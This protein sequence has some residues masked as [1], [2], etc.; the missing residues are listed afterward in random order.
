MKAKNLVVAFRPWNNYIPSSERYAD[1]CHHRLVRFRPWAGAL[2]SG[3]GS[4]EGIDL[5]HADETDNNRWIA[6]W[7]AIATAMRNLPLSER[8]VGFEARTL[9]TPRNEWRWSHRLDHLDPDVFEDTVS[10]DVLNLDGVHRQEAL[11]VDDDV[12]HWY[13]GTDVEWTRH[14]FA[15]RAVVD[16]EVAFRGRLKGPQEVSSGDGNPEDVTQGPFLNK[17][18]ADAVDVVQRQARELDAYREQRDRLVGGGAL[19]E[20]EDTLVAPPPLRAILTGTVGTSKTVVINSMVRAVGAESFLLLAPT[21]CAACNIG[22]QTIHSGLD[23]PCV[24]EEPAPQTA[25]G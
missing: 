3:W 25:V 21:G 20:D 9:D 14:N 11:S 15:T 12:P 23:I 4:T 16:E 18:Q 6:K 5:G 22:G 19:R 24:R 8:P 10:E 7:K 2:R 13:S 17:E 1:S